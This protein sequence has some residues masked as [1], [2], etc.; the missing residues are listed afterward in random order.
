MRT[1]PTLLG[2]LALML[3]ANA[4]AARAAAFVANVGYDALDADGAPPCDV[5]PDEPAIDYQ[6]NN[7]NNELARPCSLRA[8]IVL[9]NL[10]PEGDSIAIDFNPDRADTVSFFELSRK[11]AGEDAGLTG[12][13]DITTPI[14]ILGEGAS[15]NFDITQIDAR[16]L[17]DRIFDIH[18]GGSLELRR[19]SL[20]NGQAGKDADR[21]GGCVRSAGPLLLGS[22]FFYRCSAPGDGGCLSLLAGGSLSTGDTI[23]STCK[24]KGEGGGLALRAGSATFTSAT[25]ARNRA[26]LGGAIASRGDLTLYNVTADGNRAKLGGGL[27][28]LGAGDT[29]VGNCTITENG[30]VNLDAS[31]N[32]GALSVTNTIVWGAKTD[33]VGTVPT[34]GGNLEGG[35]SCGFTGTNDQQSQDPL[36]APIDDYGGLLPTRPPTR[37]VNDA[38]D[39][40]TSPAIDHGVDTLEACDLDGRKRVRAPVLAMALAA[41]D[42]GATDYQGGSAGSAEITSTPVTTATVGV[43]YRY[44]VEATN[45][46]RPGCIRYFLMGSSP[47]GMSI[48]SATGLITWTPASEG[49]V[50]VQVHASDPAGGTADTQSFT[51]AVAPAP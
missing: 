1:R 46:E 36:L 11:G 4:D 20:L 9:A 31:Q 26:A 34:G 45:A 29:T 7:P 2:V 17:G 41:T 48:D 28:L 37:F 12:D 10:S 13:L 33:C 32:T 14:S 42:S 6:P 51:I 30:G 5:D 24:A 27:A 16:R 49:N 50:A 44:D 35:T 39:T 40:I 8:A 19:V 15:G 21:S 23:F 3:L 18:P 38:G 43:P 47:P 22:V 25:F